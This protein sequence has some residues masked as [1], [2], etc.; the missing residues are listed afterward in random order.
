MSTATFCLKFFLT[1]LVDRKII[2]DLDHNVRYKILYTKEQFNSQLTTI[3]TT[4]V[5]KY[6]GIHMLYIN[7][8]SCFFFRGIKRNVTSFF[9]IQSTLKGITIILDHVEGENIEV[10][11]TQK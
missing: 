1:F 9:I 6:S 8:L 10:Q 5:V 3:K 11:I 7:K 2:F 4:V